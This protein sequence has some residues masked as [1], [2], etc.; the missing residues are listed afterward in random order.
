MIGV[1]YIA[2][3]GALG[4]VA[5]YLAMSGVTRLMG[6]GFPYGTLVVNVVG[7]C[8]MGALIG[9]LAKMLTGFDGIRLFVAVGFLG[10]FTTFSTF[11]LDVVTMFER[12]EMLSVLTYIL[13]SVTLSVLALFMGLALVRLV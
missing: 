4:A 8:L 12:G 13:G 3:G 5:R 11:S 9:V 10:S 6:H 2:L 1:L 7:S